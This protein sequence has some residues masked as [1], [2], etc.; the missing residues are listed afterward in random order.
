MTGV[1]MTSADERSIEEVQD[2][3]HNAGWVLDSLE[4]NSMGVVHVYKVSAKGVEMGLAQP[5]EPAWAEGRTSE[6]ADRN[7][8]AK[9]E[10][11]SATNPD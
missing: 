4:V 9:L 6:G 3:I 11:G 5:S 7:F 10:S 8:L 1:S 2:A